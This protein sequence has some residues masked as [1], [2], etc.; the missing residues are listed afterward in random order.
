[1]TTPP[2][3]LVLLAPPSLLPALQAGI[4]SLGHRIALA[5]DPNHLHGEVPSADVVIAV[6]STET[7]A[8]IDRLDDALFQDDRETLFDEADSRDSWSAHR[9]AEHLQP[10][11]Q[12]IRPRQPAALPD[13]APPTGE[14]WLDTELEGLEGG[15]TGLLSLTPEP[16]GDAAAAGDLE[17][18]LLQF[19]EATVEAHAAAEP[20]TPLSPGPEG[21]AAAA[22]P[23]A[24]V[25]PHLLEFEEATA[26]AP[27]QAE[28][29][30]QFNGGF[31]FNDDDEGM[32]LVAPTAAEAPFADPPPSTIAPSP[33]PAADGQGPA[34]SPPAPAWDPQA[35]SLLDD[36]DE[37]RPPEPVAPAAPPPLRPALP[38]WTL[39]GEE[40]AEEEI[41]VPAVV[42]EAAAP[43]APPPAAPAP[44]PE[45][46]PL[47]TI[48]PAAAGVLLIG[49]GLG[50]P[51]ALIQLAEFLPALPVPIAIH[52]DLP[53]GRHDVFAANLQKRSRLEVRVGTAG[54]ALPAAS[55]TVLRP[56]QGLIRDGEGW[57]VGDVDILATL[58]TLGE[59]DALLL[60]S[61]A[62]GAWVLPA[63]GT[64]TQGAMLL[65]QRPD[66]ALDSQAIATLEEI[67]LIT[68]SPEE[69]GAHLAERWGIQ[70]A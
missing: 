69:L 13:P 58:E 48:A 31:E 15:S 37:E 50:G 17:S 8:A 66:S 39:E 12:R 68:G 16:E 21:N 24:P 18:D 51:G 22:R 46:T 35:F 43:M 40:P 45:V 29:P 60:V 42:A 19:G 4:E 34:A 5:V 54:A 20:P 53:Q 57:V 62:P 14:Y 64:A 59:D 55:I 49:G 33:T 41:A 26:K 67:G 38:A 25:E 11:L 3:S 10:K 44:E 28:I 27:A 56:G 65:G 2:L 61:G 9:W 32:V 1:M 52:Q 36:A 47:V 6:L 30:T 23:T 70:A 7:E 63:M